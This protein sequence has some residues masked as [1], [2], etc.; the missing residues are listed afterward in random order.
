MSYLFWIVVAV[1]VGLCWLARPYPDPI[2][3]SRKTL[4][5]EVE[6]LEERR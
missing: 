2:H 6:E 3:R 4:A 5:D 1:L